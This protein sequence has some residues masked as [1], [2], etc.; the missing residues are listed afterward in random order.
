MLTIMNL[1][2]TNRNFNQN[3]FLLTKNLKKTK[4]ISNSRAQVFKAKQLDL[5]STWVFSGCFLLY[6]LLHDFSL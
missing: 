1:F 2:R 6:V 5:T 3:Q 4:V